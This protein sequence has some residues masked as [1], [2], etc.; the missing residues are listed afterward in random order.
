MSSNCN[1][2]FGKREREKEGG[3]RQEGDKPLT[4]P[5]DFIFVCVCQSNEEAV[6]VGV[7]KGL[8]RP[9]AYTNAYHCHCGKLKFQ[10]FVL[11]FHQQLCKFLLLRFFDPLFQQEG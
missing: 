11:I 7:T 9:F 4:N 2:L 1:I 8:A 5:G 6:A 3:G 10:S